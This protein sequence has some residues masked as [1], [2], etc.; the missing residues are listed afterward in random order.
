[1]TDTIL[2]CTDTVL[3]GGREHMTDWQVEVNHAI[4]ETGLSFNTDALLA[5]PTQICH[6]QRIT[7]ENQQL[8][9]E[10]EAATGGARGSGDPGHGALRIAAQGRAGQHRKLGGRVRDR[11]GVRLVEPGW[12]VVR[13]FLWWRVLLCAGCGRWVERSVICGLGFGVLGGCRR[14]GGWVGGC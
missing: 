5:V 8:R 13:G 11:V 4:K 14:V 3:D 7:S 9:E 2:A 1:M 10:L 12:F 6:I